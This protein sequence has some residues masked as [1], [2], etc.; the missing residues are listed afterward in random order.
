MIPFGQLLVGSD[1]F[2][3]DVTSRVEEFPVGHEQRGDGF[4]LLHQDLAAGL[5][6][7]Q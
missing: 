4:R 3:H 5:S 2:L 1:E 7:Q 6:L